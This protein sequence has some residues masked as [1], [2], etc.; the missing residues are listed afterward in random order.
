MTRLDWLLSATTLLAPVA[1]AS[2]SIAGDGSLFWF[3]SPL[4]WPALHLLPALALVPLLAPIA[5][6]GRDAA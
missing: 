6:R 2:C 3:A 5:I 4:R 1:L